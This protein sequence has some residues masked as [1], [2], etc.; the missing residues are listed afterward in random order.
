MSL[1]RLLFIFRSESVVEERDGEPF[2][3]A[4]GGERGEQCD[5]GEERGTKEGRGRGRE[6]ETE[7]ERE[8][9]RE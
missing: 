5:G 4:E 3:A 7:R 9:E 8:R 1:M 2:T 6:T